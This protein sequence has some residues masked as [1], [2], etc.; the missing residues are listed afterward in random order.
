MSLLIIF[1]VVSLAWTL[2]GVPIFHLLWLFLGLLIGFI[3]LNSD[4]FIYWFFLKPNLDES[5]Q[6]QTLFREKKYSLILT[7]IKTAQQ[8]HS[9]LIFHHFFF[10]FILAIVSFF[11]FSSS[12]SVF[13]MSFILA[14]N[15]HL[16]SD[17]FHDLKYNPK[18]LQNWLFA[19]E[20]KQLPLKNL[21]HYLLLYSL[22]NLLFLALF[23]R[24][25]I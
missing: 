19:R 12:G 25:K 16:L 7:S 18:H 11:V 17:E 24:S 20:S 1:L 13:T 10:Q 23:I 4:H 6:I 15:L 8:T 3:F 22:L 9:N 2:A 5:R 21:K 14:L